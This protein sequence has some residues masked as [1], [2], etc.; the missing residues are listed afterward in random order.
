[1]P[2]AD[3]ITRLRA[4]G[5]TFAEGLSR[6]ELDLAEKQF[7]IQFPD[8]Y[9][10]LL[11]EALPVGERFPDWRRRSDS[12]RD[13]LD[14][15]WEGMAFDIEQNSWWHE[16]WGSKPAS[17]E[18]ALRV[19]KDHVDQA[20]KLIPVCGHRYIPSEPVAAGNPIYSV[21]QMDIVYY[22]SNLEEYLEIEFLGKDH[23]MMSNSFRPIRFWRDF[24]E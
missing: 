1:M 18:D 24:V 11:R 13:S 9:R 17:L 7:G 12:M 16:A 10:E 14:W 22:G 23:S 21:Y 19:A 15:P 3:T 8:D 6:E 5:I 20:P 4:K 2:W